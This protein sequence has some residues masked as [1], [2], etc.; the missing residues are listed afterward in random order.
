[1][2]ATTDNPT[3]NDKGEPLVV[4]DKFDAEEALKYLRAN[5]VEVET[6]EDRAA[7]KTAAA[8][9]VADDAE[10]FSFV[11]IPADSTKPPTSETGRFV[12]GNG[13]VLP[14]L[15]AP[16]F[17]D[18]AVLDEDVVARET[19]NHLKGMML[20]GTGDKQNMKAPSSSSI[21]HVAQGGS[22]E[23]WPLCRGNEANNFRAVQL[24]ID[25]IG[26]LRMRP[27]NARAEALAQACGLAGVAIH[28]D[29]YVGRCARDPARG[30]ERNETFGLDELSPDAEWQ[31]VARRAHQ[32]Q[33]AQQ[34]FKDDEHLASG[35]DEESL[36]YSWTQ[37]EDDVEVRVTKGIPK[38]KG[39]KKR[40]KVLYG[41]GDSLVVKVD[42]E[43]VCNVTPLFDKVTPDECSWSLDGGT[44][45]ISMEKAEGKAWADLGHPTKAAKEAHADKALEAMLSPEMI[46]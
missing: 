13:D 2:S 17:D 25:E 21:Q 14:T 23:A 39:G 22:C 16:R 45:V 44:L 32:E 34:G 33:A 37:T 1:M 29:A 40:I 11:F 30:G 8:Q 20:G 19:A 31:V 36:G 24:Y 18:N 27:R 3:N 46:S 6:V 38:E 35:G 28:G 26:A 4:G 43:E 42:G 9:P 12:L 7:K 41:K 5:G 10:P 15:L